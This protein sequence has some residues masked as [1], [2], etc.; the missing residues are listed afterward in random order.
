[1]N[2]I[3]ACAAIAAITFLF[4]IT[5]DAKAQQG[6]NP[7]HPSSCSDGGCQH[8]NESLELIPYG[9]SFES[10]S[11]RI[12]YRD[13]YRMPYTYD[14]RLEQY[15]SCRAPYQGNYADYRGSGCEDGSC[16]QSHQPRGDQYAARS[17]RGCSSGN[18]PYERQQFE[19]E[20]YQA[21]RAYGNQ[22]P[23][24]SGYENKSDFDARRSYVDVYPTPRP[25][26]FEGY[27]RTPAD[28]RPELRTS[29]GF[30]P[31]NNYRPIEP[32]Q[33]RRSLTAPRTTTQIM[34]PPELPPQPSAFRQNSP[35]L[36]PPTSRPNASQ[37]TQ[38]HA[39]CE[40]CN[41]DH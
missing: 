2:R 15:D 28:R 4:T 40:S 7:G 27:Q 8:G 24:R 36:L 5:L 11:Q 34:P 12:P 39:G 37:S 10:A 30:Q 32:Q 14:S 9:Q 23:Y 19:Q 13:S 26:S 33:Q 25:R 38:N 35:Q 31:E 6:W 22:L 1:M 29:P 41:H 17:R 3:N 18:C 16:R 20:S 21:R